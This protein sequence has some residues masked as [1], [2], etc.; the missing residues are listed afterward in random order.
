MSD[1]IRLITMSSRFAL[2]ALCLFLAVVA[3][4]SCSADKNK[5]AQAADT[6]LKNS[7]VK[8]TKL[9]LFCTSPNA[10]DR[11]YVAMSATWGFSDKSGNPQKEFFG[12]IMQKDGDSWKIVS[13]TS[14]TDDKQKAIDYLSG[15]K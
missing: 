3:S 5:A 13:N 15:A 7:G 6:Y 11:A 9:D 2:P 10:P 8:E 12:F 1:M 4:T 14:Y